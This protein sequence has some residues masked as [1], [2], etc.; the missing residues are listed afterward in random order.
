MNT[1][2]QSL[3]KGDMMEIRMV[4]VAKRDLSKTFQYL[5]SGMSHTIMQ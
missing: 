3:L 1:T 2:D 5:I 4:R